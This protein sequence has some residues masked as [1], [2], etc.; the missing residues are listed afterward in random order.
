M[1]ETTAADPST[2][3]LPALKGFLLSE[4]EREMTYPRSPSTPLSPPE[5]KKERTKEKKKEKEKPTF[6]RCP[7]VNMCVQLAASRIL[8]RGRVGGW[9]G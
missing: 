3:C 4:R 7:D 6:Q 1:Q 8:V 5:R 9:V 2:S